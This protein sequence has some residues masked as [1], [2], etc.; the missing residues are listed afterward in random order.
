MQQLGGVDAVVGVVGNPELELAAMGGPPSASAVD[1]FFG[2]EAHFGDVEVGWDESAVWKLNR[3]CGFGV[4]E[5]ELFEF[6]ENH[7]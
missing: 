1:E 6:G 2:H 3:D 7:G 5:Q 4:F